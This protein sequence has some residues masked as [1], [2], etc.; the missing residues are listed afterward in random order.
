LF[1]GAIYL[2]CLNTLN[3]F[4]LENIKFTNCVSSLYGDNIFIYGKEFDRII[5]TEKLKGL[6][7][8]EDEDDENKEYYG[9]Q[10]SGSTYESL[11]PYLKDK[12]IYVDEMGDTGD[13]KT[14]I[15][16]CEYDYINK[17]IYN[18]FYNVFIIIIILIILIN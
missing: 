5:N 11:I 18:I 14:L 10:T 8:N 13:C 1:R 3:G 4:K 12:I 7:Y 17:L 6:N 16:P 9:T 2:N 15:S